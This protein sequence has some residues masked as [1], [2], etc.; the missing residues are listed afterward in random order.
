MAFTNYGS[1][2]WFG[3]PE[4]GITESL[5]GNTQSIYDA[6]WGS[7]AVNQNPTQNVVQGPNI[8]GSGVGMAS[9]PLDYAPSSS[10]T[11]ISSNQVGT[12]TFEGRGGLSEKEYQ[13]AYQRAIDESY[14]IAIGGL[15]QLEDS[16]YD[17]EQNFY[18]IATAPYTS[19]VPLVQQA[20]QEGES[21]LAIQRNKAGLN[22]QNALAAARRLHDELT[23]RNRQAFGSG[24]LGSVGQAAS[25]ILGRTAQQGMG[26]IRNLAAETYNNI[27]TAVVNLK[28]KVS[29]QLQSLNQQKEAALAQAKIAFQ[30]KIDY[31]NERKNEAAQAKAQNKLDAMREYRDYI[32]SI[33]QQASSLYN[34]IKGKA[35]SVYSTLVDQTNKTKAQVMDSVNTGI[36]SVNSQG[37]ANTSAYNSM[38]QGNLFKST[39]PQA[40]IE[41]LTGNINSKKEDEQYNL[42]PLSNTYLQRY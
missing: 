4:L 35:D 23:T 2:N 10:G 42:N 28:A 16:L 18:N 19:Q 3:L 7:G 15:N 41:A 32:R 17:N 22:E 24:A 14:N 20:G 13:D 38:G 6:V 26:S 36:S 40:Q 9:Y 11:P 39:S 25:E 5:G 12:Y 34:S 29:A 27:A 31:I 33:E 21:A 37:A 8:Q 1:G 30:E